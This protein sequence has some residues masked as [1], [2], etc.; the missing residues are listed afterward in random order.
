MARLVY[1]ALCSLDLIH[2]DASG[3]FSF[4]MPDEEVHSAANELARG[5]GIMLLG[6]RMYETLKAWETMETEGQPEAIATFKQLW[7]D[8]D[9]VVYSRTLQ[10]PETERTRIETEFD[11]AAV[12]ELVA[13]SGADVSISG[14]G[15]AAEALRAGLVDEL[16]LFLNP[17]IVG[18]GTSVLPA[19]LR[20]GLELVDER[21][22]ANGTVHLRHRVSNPN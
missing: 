10:E 21:R 15:I 19:G 2:E 4:A 14:P 22:F 7:L 8:A 20:L 13:G 6:R 16:H 11:P 18:G 1:T 12:R 5:V 3:D 9:K 17:V